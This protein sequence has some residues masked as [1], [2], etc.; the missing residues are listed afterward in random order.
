VKE[1]EFHEAPLVRF[2][3]KPNLPVLGPRLGKAL[4]D[5]QKA[6]A[7][8]D[9]ESL[10]DGGIRAAGHDL[11]PQDLIIERADEPGWVHS[12]HLSVGIDP[13][14]DDELLLEGRVLD[15]IHQLNTMR[16]DAGLELTDRIR[17]R[18][19]EADADLLQHKAWIKEEVLAT[20]I[21]T[22]AVAEPQITKVSD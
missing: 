3:Y 12:D 6:L 16:K 13:R 5:V 15:L 22:D 2:N 9:F 10:P 19:P 7:E 14:L 17:V 4:R 18:L 20:E 11:D 21:R 8:K 1:V